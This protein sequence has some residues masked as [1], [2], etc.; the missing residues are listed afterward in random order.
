M[1]REDDVRDARVF[2][3]SADFAAVLLDQA[4]DL[5]LRP[6]RPLRS[7]AERCQL[8]LSLQHCRLRAFSG[9]R[10]GLRQEGRLMRT[11]LA[12]DVERDAGKDRLVGCFGRVQRAL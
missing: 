2:N 11:D 10:C 7:E 3:V 6:A 1:L 8:F 4:R 5:A 12:V 9:V